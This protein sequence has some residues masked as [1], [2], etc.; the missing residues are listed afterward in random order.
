[1]N[2][3]INGKTVPVGSASGLA[4][5]DTPATHGYLDYGSIVAAAGYAVDRVL[6]VVYSTRR[7]GDEQREGSLTLGQ[8]VR[9]EDG[10]VFSVADTSNA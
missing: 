3:I 9:I 7:K 8:S 10:M 5:S 4:F 1:M 2:I 6:T